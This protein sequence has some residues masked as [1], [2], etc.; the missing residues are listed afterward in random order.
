MIASA[1]A[2][3]SPSL[4]QGSATV[5]KRYLALSVG[6]VEATM[7][8]RHWLRGQYEKLMDA[9]EWEASPYG[10]T[11]HVGELDGNPVNISI[12]S[13]LIGGHKILFINPISEVVD[14]R[15]ITK[16]LQANV[17][18][19]AKKSGRLNK[20]DAGNFSNVFPSNFN[21]R[22][23]SKMRSIAEGMREVFGAAQ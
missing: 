12:Y 13:I 14:H 9:G 6:V 3:L 20:V 11:A 15:L 22:P 17:P 18:A 4:D 19:S 8:E 2:Y 21:Q 5:L 1:A 10:I 16:W 7:F 23:L